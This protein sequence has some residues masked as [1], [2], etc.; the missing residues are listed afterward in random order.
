MNKQKLYNDELHNF[1]SLPDT[2]M[3]INQGEQDGHVEC[4][5]E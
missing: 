1:Y 5:K 4:K 2:V 3:L